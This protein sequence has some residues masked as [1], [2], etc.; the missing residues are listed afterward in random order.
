MRCLE[1]LEAVAEEDISFVHYII[2][3]SSILK[4]EMYTP[5]IKETRFIIFNYKNKSMYIYI[6]DVCCVRQLYILRV[7]VGKLRGESI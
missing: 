5:K 6:A 4:T 3:V 1:N 2:G 7:V